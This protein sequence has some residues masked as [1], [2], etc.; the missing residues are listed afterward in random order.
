MKLVSRIVPY[1]SRHFRS[2]YLHLRDS[3]STTY[4]IG[5]KHRLVSLPLVIEQESN[6]PADVI[7][8]YKKHYFDLLGS[9]WTHVVHGKHFRGFAGHCYYSSTIRKINKSN[10]PY[11]ESVSRLITDGYTPIDWQVDIK[12]GYRWSERTHFTSVRFGNL[13]GVDVKLPWELARM[14]H[15]VHLAIDYSGEGNGATGRRECVTKFQNQVLDF[16][17]N[18]PPGFGVNWVCP[19]D[20]AIRISNILLAYDIFAKSGHKFILSFDNILANSINDH[21]QHIIN[22]LEWYNGKIRNNHYLSDIIGLLFCSCHLEKTDI[23]EAWFTFAVSELINE[24]D[25]QFTSEGTN[26]EGSTCYHRLSTELVVWGTSVALLKADDLLDNTGTNSTLRHIYLKNKRL[27]NTFDD[28]AAVFPTR[29]IMK[30]HKMLSFLEDIRYGLDEIPQI[31]DNDSGRLFKLAPQYEKHTVESV[32]KAYSNLSGYSD[33]DITDCYLHELHLNVNSVI[34]AGHSLFSGNSLFSRIGCIEKDVP[35]ITLVP[36]QDFFNQLD[37]SCSN[38]SKTVK[39]Q[40]FSVS[41]NNYKENLKLIRYDKFGIYLFRSDSLYLLVRAQNSK[42]TN[43]SHSHYDQLSLELHIDGKALILDPG[44]NVY[45]ADPIQRNLYRGVLAHNSPLCLTNKDLPEPEKNIFRMIKFTPCEI[46]HFSETGFYGLMKIDGN[47]IER[48]IILHKTNIEV[49]DIVDT[50]N[51]S[52]TEYSSIPFSPGY[53]I[54]KA[55]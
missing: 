28:L 50:I 42:P 39:R 3:L 27:V 53:G 31:G 44:T 15:L 4:T 23:T 17:A 47:L 6:I 43:S 55:S 14:H 12:S 34:A 48:F 32:K 22:N 54:V 7:E 36:R 5:S 38:V 30:L 29:Y 45:T 52:T 20:V 19:M 16:I 41:E 51:L 18:N 49:I 35:E 1:I 13:P 11:S 40:S 25:Y 21:G 26:F 24:V 33:L 37:I 8:L 2:L 10:R 9:G 46:M